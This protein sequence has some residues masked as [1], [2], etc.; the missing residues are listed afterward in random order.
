MGNTTKEKIDERKIKILNTAFDIFVEKTIEAVSMGEI[1]EAAGVGRAT[2]FRYYPSKLELVIEVC[3]KKWKD[4]FDELD[5]CRPISSVG[6][7]PAL[8]RLIF[9]LDTYIA[10]YQNYKELLCYNDNFNHYVSRVGEDNERLAEFHESLYSVDVRLHNMYEKAKEDKSFRTD[11]PE[12]EFMRVTVQTMMGA[13]EHYAKGF[14]WGS[15]KEHDYTQELLRLKE[16]IINYVT[17]GC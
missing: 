15:E 11:I 6:E 1:A 14:I 13:G 5:R 2:L 4:V 3:G 16:M 7:I 9:T 17:I 8:D 12:G 10:L